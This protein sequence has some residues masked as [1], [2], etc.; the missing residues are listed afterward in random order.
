MAYLDHAATTPVRPEVVDAMVPLLRGGHGNPSGS[1]RAAQRAKAALEE[2]RER[3]AAVLGCR[4]GEVVLTSGGTEAD[5]L[6][7]KGAAR[8]ARAAGT[9]DG[10]VVGAAE[11]KAVLAAAARLRSEG[12]RVALAPVGPDGAVDPDRLAGLLDERTVAV[13]VMLVNNEVGSVQDLDR[14]AA[15]VRDR[16]PRAVLHTDAVQAAPWLDLRAAAAPAALVSVTGHKLGG[17]VGTGA[18]VIRTGTVVTP[19]I[20]GGGQER[21]L[22]CGTSDVAG[23]VGFATALE[24]AAA[25]RD[26]EGPRLA[27][28]RDRLAAGLETLG[29]VERHGDPSRTVPGIWNGRIVGVQAEELLVL[30]DATDVQAAAGASCSSGAAEPSHVLSA[31]GVGRDAARESIR[32]S[33]G[34]TSTGADVDAA[35]AA[36]TAAVERLRA[37]R[38]AEPVRS[39]P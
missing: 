11:H 30:L 19:E 6:A 13:S 34:H 39:R 14:I 15:V 29:G 20:E 3:I 18:L 32:L 23:A 12:F 4:P 7:V 37:A 24:L 25:R 27:A 33:L 8:E 22:R 17:P 5:N 21:G 9:G 38:V 28:L 10:V 16:A 36:I 31:M 2:A 1:H 35:L 26:A